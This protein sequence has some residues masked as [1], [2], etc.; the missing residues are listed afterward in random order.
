MIFL[1]GAEDVCFRDKYSYELFAN[2]PQVR[3][4]TDIVFNLDVSSIHVTNRKRVI[5]SII[6]CNSKME[7]KYTKA[8]EQKMIEMTKFALDHGYEVCYMSFCRKQ[9]D[10]E[11]IERIIQQC[12]EELQ[13]QIQTYYYR[14]NIQEALQTLADCQ[15]IVGT[16]FHSIILG[17]LF[18]K[19]IIPMIYSNKTKQVLEDL[20]FEGQVVDIATIH[21]LPI[22]Q[23]WNEENLGYS[24]DITS[25][26]QNAQKQFEGLDKILKEG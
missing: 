6:D 5:F 4:A 26:K 13:K 9:K 21:G 2:I 14:G 12:D 18:H 25:I 3:Y 1:N 20:P 7:P 22:E 23:V 11:A 10:E 17:L 15:I 16:R 24:L 8:Y 19:K